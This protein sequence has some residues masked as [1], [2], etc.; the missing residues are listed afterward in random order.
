MVICRSINSFGGKGEEGNLLALHPTVKPVGL[1]SDAIGGCGYPSTTSC[2][3]TDFL[4]AVLFALYRGRAHGCSAAAM[5]WKFI[6]FVC[7]YGD[8]TLGTTIRS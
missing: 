7:R 3:K 6:S 8:R 2:W 5:E 1:L 4:V